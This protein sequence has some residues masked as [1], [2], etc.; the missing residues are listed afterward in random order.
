MPSKKNKG[1]TQSLVRTCAVFVHDFSGPILASGIKLSND[2]KIKAKIRVETTQ[3]HEPSITLFLYF[4]D[5][6]DN[7]DRGH[8]ARFVCKNPLL[9][10]QLF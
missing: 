9:R 2:I 3:G 6:T 7:E 10:T 1:Y 5:S 8:G 4:P